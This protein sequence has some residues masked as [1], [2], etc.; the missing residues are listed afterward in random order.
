MGGSG[1]SLDLVALNEL[2]ELLEEGLDEL[3]VEYLADSSRQL[4]S[5]RAAVDGNDIPAIDST[6]HTL[7]GSSGNLGIRG[8][9]QLCAAMEREAKSGALVDASASLLAIEEE[10]AK[11]KG[12]I[13]IYMAG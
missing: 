6:A 10:Y 7:K 12:A 8:V 11:A 9:Y 13:A 1:D 4:S 2:K 3:L 5:L